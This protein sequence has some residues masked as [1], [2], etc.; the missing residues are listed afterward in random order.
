VGSR[1]GSSGARR[2]A[3]DQVGRAGHSLRWE[4]TCSRMWHG[5]CRTNTCQPCEGISR[6]WALGHS[7]TCTLAHLHT[8]T[9]AH[10]HNWHLALMPR[11]RAMTSCCSLREGSIQPASTCPRQAYPLLR[12]EWDLQYRRGRLGCRCHSDTV[13]LLLPIG[14]DAN[15]HRWLR[16]HSA[17]DPV[18]A[19]RMRVEEADFFAYAPE[20]PFDLIYDFT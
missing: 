20:Q 6:L 19:G 12:S 15:H 17:D 3:E 11:R 8:C 4:S 16:E 1:R 10:L 9:L 18:L 5:G 2:S 7:D 14:L 13:V